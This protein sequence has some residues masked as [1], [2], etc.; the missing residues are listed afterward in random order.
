MSKC[1]Q[2]LAPCT[3]ATMLWEHVVLQPLA[4][5]R[6]TVIFTDFTQSILNGD[7]GSFGAVV[8]NTVSIKNIKKYTFMMQKYTKLKIHRYA[9]QETQQQPEVVAVAIEKSH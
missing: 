5:K 9:T 6:R 8:W 1:L 2:V 7:G 3:L 4:M